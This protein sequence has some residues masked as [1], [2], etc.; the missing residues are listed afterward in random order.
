MSV[1]DNRRPWYCRDAAVNEYKTAIHS[2]GE[3]FPMLKTLKIL[4][5][6]IVN[7]GVLAVGG[8]G[9]YLG[10]DPTL[11]GFVTLAV[12]GAYNGLEIGDYLALLQAYQEVQ[13]GI[14]DDDSDDE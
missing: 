4:R 7:I 10:G 2:E 11:L 12:V 14:T 1:P 6:I 3:K 9:M 13:A 5:A 8:Y